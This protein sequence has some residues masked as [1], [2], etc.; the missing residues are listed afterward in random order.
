MGWTANAGQSNIFHVFLSTRKAT[1]TNQSWNKIS[2]THA[3]RVVGSGTLTG[4]ICSCGWQTPGFHSSPKGVHQD[5]Q[6]HK[7]DK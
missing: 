7:E 1:M 4:G 5:F 3:L 2:N 6:T